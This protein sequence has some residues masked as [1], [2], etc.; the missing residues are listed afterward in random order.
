MKGNFQDL[1]NSRMA[2]R[3]IELDE[4][5]VCR[6]ISA[7]TMESCP[8]GGLVMH[9]IMSI[10]FSLRTSKLAMAFGCGILQAYHSASAA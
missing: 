1:V 2:R 9:I 8:E 6:L 10:S 7:L 5:A 4:E 3:D